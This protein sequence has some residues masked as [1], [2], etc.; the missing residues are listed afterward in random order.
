M[1]RDSKIATA[2]VSAALVSIVAIYVIGGLP[3]NEEPMPASTHPVVAGSLIPAPV[4]RVDAAGT[5]QLAGATVSGPLSEYAADVL[6]IEVSAAGS[7]VLAVEAGAPE[8]YTLEATDTGVRIVGGD[9]HGVFNG[10]QSLR[11]LVVDGAI[12]ATTI[13]DAPRFAYRGAMLDVVRHFFSVDEV[14]RY[15][16]DIVMLKINHLHLHLT[17]DQG[18]RI[19]IESWPKLTEVGAS[20]QVDGG[21]GGFYTQ[22]EY[23]EIV[24]YAAS[25]FVTIVPEIDMPGHT[26]AALFAYPELT[27]DGR[28]VEAYEGIEVGFS[29]FCIDN[30]R[31]YDF[32]D[33]VM[34]ELAEITPGPYLHVG[35]DEAHS[36]TDED[37]L[38][39]TARATQIAAQYDKT[40]IGWHEI[41]RSDA[42]PSGTVGQY[43]S[44]TTPRDGAD[45]HALSIVEQ[46]GRLIMSPADAAYID[47]KYDISQPLGNDWADGPTTLHEA[48]NWDPAD[49]VPGI[50]D[51]QLLGVEAPLWTETLTTIDELELLAFPRLAAIA[52]IGWS[53]REGR[54]WDEFAARVATFGTF[55]D[56]EG[57]TYFRVPEVPWID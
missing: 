54:A 34:R 38:A 7:I 22:D 9:E 55:L 35:G 8:S 5:F 46:G 10:I 43:W 20:T 27:C 12:G 1:T 23:A 17:D 24:E 45:A 2:I 39:F 49:V 51:A 28:K 31:T 36:T 21:G 15:I 32:I 25:R 56:A 3:R 47:M 14:K 42:L 11:Q 52:E 16:D 53:P 40:L 29:S 26:N 50:G 48:Y 4:S 37:Y 19:E 6:G 33:D 30:E 18:W 44:F 13:E 57:V 41:G